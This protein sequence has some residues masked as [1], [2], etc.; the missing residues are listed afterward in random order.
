[1]TKRKTISP[2]VVEKVYSFAKKIFS[3]EISFQTVL[4]GLV[5]KDI[6]NKKSADEYLKNYSSMRKGENFH[7]TMNLYAYDYY[8]GNIY[9]DNGKEALKLALESYSR[10]LNTNKNFKK[11]DAKKYWDIY[12]KYKV[13]A[14][15]E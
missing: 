4:D 10:H 11:I 3:N 9:K 12:N 6:M 7:W 2:D 13:I 1:M 8:L 5:N 15:E 14:E